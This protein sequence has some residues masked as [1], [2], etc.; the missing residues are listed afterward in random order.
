MERLT[1][2]QQGILMAQKRR[3]FAKKYEGMSEYEKRDSDN[4]TKK[5]GCIIGIT[6]LI[7]S[8]TA[9]LLK[10]LLE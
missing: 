9:I 6:I 10:S 1:R 5:I 2:Q 3:E 8:F 7:I 4:G